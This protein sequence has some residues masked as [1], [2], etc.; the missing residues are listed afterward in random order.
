MRPARELRTAIDCM[1]V[2]T[3]RA[4]LEGIG[5]SSIIVGGYTDGQGGICP[6]LAAHRNGGR[7]AFAAFA[8]AWDRYTKADGQRRRATERE[9]RTLAAMLQA[10]IEM[11]DTVGQ[12]LL[13][14]AVRDHRAAQVRRAHRE[15]FEV[16]PLGPLRTRPRPART[17][18]PARSMQ[19]T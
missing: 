12:G 10:S 13:G 15:E 18:P 6:M 7:T 4:M 5:D 2:A 1:P 17:G 8:H 11:E 9:V 19:L 16:T 3:R 14:E